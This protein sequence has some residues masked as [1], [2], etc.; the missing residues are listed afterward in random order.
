MLKARRPLGD[1]VKT[2]RAIERARLGV[3]LSGSDKLAALGEDDGL[4]RQAE[5]RA[6]AA[7]HLHEDDC[8]SVA[9]DNIDPPA[10]QR[11]CAKD[12]SRD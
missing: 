9:R 4:L 3:E 8:L 6:G 1:D 2:H 5:R 12:R 10:R 7:A 11:K